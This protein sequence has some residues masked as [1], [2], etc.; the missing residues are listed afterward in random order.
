V[1]QKTE[2]W[3]TVIVAGGKGLRMGGDTPKQLIELDGIPV[4]IYTVQSFLKVVKEENTV[5]VVP[6]GEEDLYSSFLEQFIKQ[7]KKIN[8]A[9]GGETRFHSVKN[10]LN[11]LTEKFALEGSIIGIHDA[12]RC[13][14]T[15]ELIQS[16]YQQA[17]NEGCAI[18]VVPLKDSIRKLKPEAGKSKQVNRDNY[19]AV[20]TP[21][22]FDGVSIIEAYEASFEPHFTDC[23]SVFEFA[24]N[25][26]ALCGGDPNNIKM[27]TPDDLPLVKELILSSPK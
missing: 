18:P 22:V 14:I 9:T 1:Q 8:I 3:Y 21:Q 15:S 6:N 13:L 12:A 27:T 5:L 26:V 17:K 20:Q 11:L 10:G 4:F 7:G 23:S 24:G 16:I 2:N 25:E 19:V